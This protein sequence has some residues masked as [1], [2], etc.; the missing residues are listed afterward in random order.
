MNFR[1]LFKKAFE[2]EI[3]NEYN[4]A[5]KYMPA[6]VLS[7][8]LENINAADDP[9]S[10]KG[11]YAGQLAAL[12]SLDDAE[13][14]KVGALLGT[15]GD[16]LKHLQAICDLPYFQRSMSSYARTKEFFVLASKLVEEKASLEDLQERGIVGESL[17]QTFLG[18]HSSY[19]DDDGQAFTAVALAPKKQRQTGQ[20]I[21][22]HIRKVGGCQLIVNAP[23][24]AMSLQRSLEE[25]GAATNDEAYRLFL[26][27]MFN[28]GRGSLVRGETPVVLVNPVVV[29]VHGTYLTSMTTECAVRG[30]VEPSPSYVL[31]EQLV[32]Q[33]LMSEYRGTFELYGKA[34][35][36]GPAVQRLQRSAPHP[37]A[38]WW[39]LRPG[40]KDPRPPQTAKEI[41]E[42]ASEFEEAAAEL[43][44]THEV[45][46]H[47]CTDAATLSKRGKPREA[48]T[49]R[50]RQFC[51]TRVKLAANTAAAFQAA[52]VIFVAQSDAGSKFRDREGRAA[53][54]FALEAAV[55]AMLYDV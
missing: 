32:M 55:K 21:A 54:Q 7:V 10:R 25:P 45:S 49:E 9:N 34:A 22:A 38:L 46:A 37:D 29:H 40:G 17:R 39:R 6:F 31:V 16:D 1:E 5:V 35:T 50:L 36:A 51:E 42:V 43:L 19:E 2:T 23:A 14:E 3:P 44:Q 13:K 12:Y 4:L 20:K 15:S 18:W 30:F 53:A 28:G 33:E 11:T 26:T 24:A 52:A 8:A 27:I 47:S 41:L 48:T